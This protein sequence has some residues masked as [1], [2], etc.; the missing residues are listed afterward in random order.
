MILRKFWECHSRFGWS[1]CVRQFF[2]WG[3]SMKRNVL[4]LLFGLFLYLK[5]DLNW[6]VLKTDCFYGIGARCLTKLQR[7]FSGTGQ[8]VMYGTDT[9]NDVTLTATPSSDVTSTSTTHMTL[10]IVVAAVFVIFVVVI[11]VVIKVMKRK[12]ANPNGYTLTSTGKQ[13][14]ILSV[15]NLDWL[16]IFAS[17]KHSLP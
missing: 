17:M 2:L 12:N 14:Y 6:L 5:G 16:S 1:D 3:W 11:V 4:E 7:V 10:Y 13:L 15:N 9:T 8:L